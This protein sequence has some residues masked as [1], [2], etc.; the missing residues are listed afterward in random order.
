MRFGIVGAGAIGCLFGARLTLAGYEV[1]LIHRDPSI[2]RTIQKNGI[3]IREI[4]RK[5]KWVRVPARKGPAQLR[6]ID[7]L[8]VAVKAFDTSAMA[9]S[10]RGLLPRETTILS[11]QNGL[12]NVEALRSRL[13]NNLLAGS[14]TE[15]ALSSGPGTVT[16]T[17]RG[18]T[19]IGDPR[20]VNTNISFRIKSAFDEAGFHT[21]ISSN[22]KGVLWT[23][24]IVNAA[25]NPLSTLTRL[26]NGKL[27]QNA[28]VQELARRTMD[29]GI[30]V[31]HAARVKLVGDPKKL[32][33]RILWS[34]RANKSSMLQDIERGK[35]TEIRQLN[36]ALV[37]YGEKM[38]VKTPINYV[39]TKL[40]QG[41]EKSSKAIGGS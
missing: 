29:E 3:G 9:A 10:Y 11:L 8:I 19:F 23:K 21:K 36:G 26:P 17:G 4:D 1:T 35:R 28:Q 32:W 37:R 2:V 13:K 6:G 16:H 39:L 5:I 41:L 27:A 38:H 12:G 7:V 20:S 15:G 40:V 22:I 18:L 33:G 30:L 24:T 34:T 25:V 31:S 14:T